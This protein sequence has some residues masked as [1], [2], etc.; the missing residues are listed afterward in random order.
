[1]SQSH[2][3]TL[4]PSSVH[5]RVGDATVT[6]LSDGYVQ[7]ELSQFVTNVPLEDAIAVQQKALRPT[8]FLL[9]VNLY[10]V[11]SP[12]HGPI[13]IDTGLGSLVPTAGHLPAALANAGVAPEDIETILLT[14][15]HG[16]HVSGLTDADGK[17][18]FANAEVVVHKAEAA[19]WLDS[20]I[21]TIRD[22]DGAAIAR[23]ALAPYRDR[24]QLIDGGEV[25]PDI[26][27]VLLPG[28]TPGHVGYQIGHG[29][30]AILVWGDIVGL[31]HVQ[32]AL[33]D[34]GFLTDFDG[35]LAA[36][37]R[38]KVFARAADE[39]LLVAG[40]HMEFPGVAN[41]VRDGEGFRLLPAPWT[42]R[43]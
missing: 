40:M 23:R 33:P 16:D 13:L 38:R 37:T 28:H 34:A 32:S 14:H 12:Q 26:T 21:G 27:A 11:R 10:L 39:S 17:A 36:D 43:Q 24:L 41:V 5:W 35:A 4:P 18:V 20:D 3:K 19:Y 2:G 15:L 9:E 6:T 42:A 22:A 25:A 1:M 31:P 8:S 29:P 7:L 30:D